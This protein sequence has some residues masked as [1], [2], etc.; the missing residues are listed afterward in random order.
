M[1]ATVEKKKHLI[2]PVNPDRKVGRPPSR[3]KLLTLRLEPEIV[4]FYRE[5]A[6]MNDRGWLQEVN[7]TLKRAMLKRQQRAASAVQTALAKRHK[8]G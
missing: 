3:K 8:N 6:R 4:D 7:D 1:D 2:Q 5:T